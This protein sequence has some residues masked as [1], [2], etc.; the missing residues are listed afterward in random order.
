MMDKL[1]TTEA[2][3]ICQR[4]LTNL[5]GA[6]VT[7]DQSAIDA[8]VQIGWTSANAKPLIFYDQI[9]MPLDQCYDLVRQAGATLRGM[10]VVRVLLDAEQPFS[11]GAT[12]FRDLGIQ[13]ALAQEGKIISAMTF[14]SRQDVDDLLLAILAPFKKAEET[15]ADSMDN[16]T[17]RNL[18]S[19]RAA[20]VNH[21]VSTARP[22]PSMLDYWFGKPLPSLV[23][24]QKL[25]G[26]ARRYDEI[27]V[28][29]KVV[30]PAFC[31][32]QGKALSQ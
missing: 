23:I 11:L 18:V 7:K 8:K 26:D 17:Y 12:L 15:A 4:L 25:Y 22:L 19:L 27:R 28:E 32:P 20:I 14:Q 24:S 21:L 5:I 3:Q 16:M 13:L 30:H 10:E 1:D 9:W 29:N 31:P 2:E 6:I